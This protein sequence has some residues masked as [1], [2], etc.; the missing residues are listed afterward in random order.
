MSSSGQ[1]WNFPYVYF[2]G[3]SKLKLSLSIFLVA[4]WIKWSTCYQCIS[5]SCGPA[6]RSSCDSFLGNELLLPLH[7][8]T[9]FVR[10]TENANRS[11]APGPT[12]F[13]YINWWRIYAYV[14]FV[15]VLT[16]RLFCFFG[17]CTFGLS[18]WYSTLDL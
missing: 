6:L 13:L 18:Y 16:F 7:Q 11:C 4:I 9:G 8:T 2:I 3:I 1:N 10:V 12:P 17:L 14:I 5:T 15:F